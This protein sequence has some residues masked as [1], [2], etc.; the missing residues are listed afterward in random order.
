MP[1]APPAEE[2]LELTPQNL[3]ETYGRMRSLT[4]RAKFSG[5]LPAIWQCS[6]ESQSIKKA[7][8][9]YVYNYPSFNL[10]RVGALLDPA[11]LATAAHHGRDLVIFGGSHI[12]ADVASGY[13]YIKRADDEQAP[14][15]GMLAR[16]LRDYLSVYRRAT[17]LIKI[18]SLNQQKRIEI[19][20]KYLF[21]KPISEQ[22]RI[23]LD[24]GSLTEGDAL[25]EGTLGKIYRLH[26]AIIAANQRAM[27]NLT[28]TPEP[29]GNMLSSTC[30]SFRKRLDHDS[31]EPQSM[32]EASIYDFMP[33]IVTSQLP[34]RR[35][36]NIN[37]WRQ[38]HQLAS[39]ITDEFEGQG[40]NIFVL[41]GLTVDQ[42][43]RHNTFIP[44]FGFWMENGNALEAKYYGPDE[45]NRLLS[46]QPVYKPPVTFL[47]YAGL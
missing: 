28:E 34:H 10:G 21:K 18:S 22:V 2:L 20:Y 1:L 6:D 26:P 15:C 23:Q 30:F 38:F 40:R 39:F 47:E 3:M 42:S 17:Q 32:I 46:E 36:C 44:Q 12:G 37:T 9:G 24:L 13:G 14:C 7:L 41:A 19:P 29:I 27:Q 31:H 5:T 4:D 8:F 16:I 33:D 45:I 35:L 43:I 25:G 11:R